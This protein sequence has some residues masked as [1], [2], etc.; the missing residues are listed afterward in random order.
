MVPEAA[1]PAVVTEGLT[2]VF[3]SQGREIAAVRDVSLEIQPGELFGLFG[4][5]GAGKSTLV[6]MLTTLLEP[7]AGQARVQGFDV[8]ADDLRARAATGLVTADERAFYGR[9]TPRRNLAFYAALQNVPRRAIADRVDA[10]LELF[11]LAAKADVP[12]QSLSTGQKQRLNMARALVHDPPVLFLDEPTKSMDV[13]TADFVKTLIKDDLVGRQGKTVVFISHELY[14][15]DAFCDRVAILAEG[16]VRAVG[17]PEVLGAR[18]PRRAL[19]RLTVTGDAD[20]M[21]DRWRA[22]ARVTSVTEVSQGITMTAFDVA[23]ADESTGVW[24]DVMR[25]V[26]DCGG[27]VE[28]YRRL[29]DG[30]LRD[31][32][33]FFT[34]EEG[35][36]DAQG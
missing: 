28:E 23:L 21:V 3:H 2:K 25:V 32:V 10:V 35:M 27:R 9:L 30:S 24:L 31:V 14:E 36:S 4:A 8:V 11:G 17:T 13:Q 1:T 26:D 20:R 33:R 18:L 16:V 22:L 6:R 5:N 19:Y 34:T 29:D 15:M 7:T 12:F